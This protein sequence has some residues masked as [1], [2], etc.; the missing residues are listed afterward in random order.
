[1]PI[2]TTTTVGPTCINPLEWI[3]GKF[4]QS[5]GKGINKTTPPE[6]IG[7]ILDKGIV[8]PN[9]DF[10]CPCPDGVYSLASVETFLKLE[11]AI[12]IDDPGRC[13]NEF[14]PS[15]E[16]FLDC[17]GRNVEVWDR[18]LDKGI[19]EWGLIEDNSQ[20]PFLF[21]WI[22]QVLISG[23]GASAPAILDVFLDKGVVIFCN[24]ETE[25]I[26]IASVET[27]LKYAELPGLTG[28]GYS[29]CCNNVFASVETYLKY[30]EA[31]GGGGG[32]VPA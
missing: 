10:C 26:V 27:Y 25:E 5:I 2:T 16:E 21:E 8:M 24:E 28:E 32:P 14:N 23:G 20:L 1:M 31:V 13:C 12:E 22:N 19:V 15:I 11:E 6:A 30:A 3:L 9:C 29:T 7:I 18:L 4:T 17:H